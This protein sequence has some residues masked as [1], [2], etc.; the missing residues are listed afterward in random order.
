[1]TDP[2]DVL[3]PLPNEEQEAPVAEQEPDIEVE[4]MPAPIEA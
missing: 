3:K 4:P 2:A 1:V